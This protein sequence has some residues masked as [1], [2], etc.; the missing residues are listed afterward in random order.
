M[1]I[2][3][4]AFYLLCKLR[5]TSD[6]SNASILQLGNQSGIVSR[7]QIKH[8]AKKFDFEFK[9]VKDKNYEFYRN[10]PTGDEIFKLLGFKSIK[11]LDSSN[12]E[13]A[14]LIYDLNTPITNDALGEYDFVYDGGTTEHIFDQLTVL[15]NLYKLLKIGGFVIHH[16]PANNFMDHGYHQPSPSFYYEYYMANGFELIESYLIESTYDFFRKRKIYPYKPLMYEHLSYGGWGNNLISNWFVFRK[17]DLSTSG[18]VPQQHRYTN[19]FHIYTKP[20]KSENEIYRRIVLLLDRH[21]AL[22]YYILQTKHW[23]TKITKIPKF[24]KKQKKPKPLFYA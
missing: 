8:I 6:F 22:K 10:Y 20:P 12:F 13:D 21:Q 9:F 23:G 11:S 15:D 14:T 16:T 2:A 1:G 17:T 18:K 19:Y 4:E 7:R 5:K 24:I 3:R